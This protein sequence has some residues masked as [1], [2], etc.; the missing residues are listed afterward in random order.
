MEQHK[1]DITT[2]EQLNKLITAGKSVLTFLSTKTG[3]R[4][5]YKFKVHNEPL[6][7]GGKF[8]K[9]I[10]VTVLNEN[11]YKFIGTIFIGN[12]PKFFWSD[13]SPISPSS[14]IIKGIDFITRK[15]FAGE[16]IN[17]LEVYHNGY[18]VR[19]GRILTV[20]E[21]I[22]TGIGPECAKKGGF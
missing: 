8:S 19:C 18:C 14:P 22:T 6:R 9:L 5:T 11:K 3:T 17:D 4:I 7:G 21:S 10:F 20:P 1:I 16:I 15:T 13:K 2:P 12:N